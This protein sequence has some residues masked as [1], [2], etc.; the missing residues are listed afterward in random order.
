MDR[1]TSS[2]S[3]PRS[4]QS[5]KLSRNDAQTLIEPWLGFS[6]LHL[7]RR[8]DDR[9]DRAVVAHTRDRRSGGVVGQV[10][11]MARQDVREHARAA[12]APLVQDGGVE[13]FLH[14]NAKGWTT[15]WKPRFVNFG[16]R[17]RS[18]CTRW[19]IVEASDARGA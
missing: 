12:L 10:R 14:L 18:M 2:R 15:S 19:R 5:P 1:V 9:D 17:R 11:A 4:N 8:R 3:H 6:R 16:H 7:R 13:V